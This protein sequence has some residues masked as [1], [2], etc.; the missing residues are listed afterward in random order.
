MKVLLLLR[1]GSFILSI[2]SKNNVKA[3]VT[4]YNSYG[5]KVK[6]QTGVN[7]AKGLNKLSLNCSSFA[8]G[9]YM[10]EVNLGNSKILKK[11]VKTN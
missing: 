3:Q 4:I 9:V 1:I 11:I 6:E 5:A 10:I 7:L 8:S 2:N